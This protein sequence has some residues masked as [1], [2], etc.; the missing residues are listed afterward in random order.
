MGTGVRACG[1]ACAIAAR[2]VPTRRKAF[3]QHFKARIVQAGGP[4]AL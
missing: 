1:N 2:I 3:E 4:T